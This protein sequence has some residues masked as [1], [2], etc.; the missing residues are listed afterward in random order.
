[1]CVYI[2]NDGRR[3]GINIIVLYGI[4]FASIYIGFI[5]LPLY[6]LLRSFIPSKLGQQNAQ[7]HHTA[8]QQKFESNTLCSKCGTENNN[9]SSSCKSCGNQLTLD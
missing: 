1:M 2:F 3:R 7:T 5:T 9:Q 6:L 4:C 8:T